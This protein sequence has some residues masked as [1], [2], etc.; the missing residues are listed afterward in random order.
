[1]DEMVFSSNP[2]STASQQFLSSFDCKPRLMSLMPGHHEIEGF[3]YTSEGQ[4]VENPIVVIFRRFNESC[5]C[6]A[7]SGFFDC[8]T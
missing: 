4:F 6:V 8:A 3:V 5:N 1:M 7:V 2:F